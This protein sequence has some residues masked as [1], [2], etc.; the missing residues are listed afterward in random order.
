MTAKKPPLIGLTGYAGSGKDAARWIL[1]DAHQFTGFAFADPIRGMLRE[2]LTSTGISTDCMDVR[3]LKEAVIPELGVSYRQLAQTLGT[4][5]ARACLGSDFWLRCARAY[6][7]DLEGQFLETSFVVS[8]VRFLNEAEWVREQGGVIWRIYRPGQP[9][10]R[11]HASE[12]ELDQIRPDRTIHNG[13]TLIDLADAIKTAL[14]GA[15]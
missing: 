5:W 8:D 4:E 13:G 7:D 6:M 2:L 9:P 3:E 14:G 15:A 10:V 11:P 12:T 1:E